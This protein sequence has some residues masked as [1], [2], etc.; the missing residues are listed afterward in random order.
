MREGEKSSEIWVPFERAWRGGYYGEGWREGVR[1]GGREE[2]KEGKEGQ[3]ERG[4]DR[5]EYLPSIVLAEVAISIKDGLATTE[6]GR[7]GGL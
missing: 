3:R 5:V 6:G 7:E 1:N 4:G 2:R